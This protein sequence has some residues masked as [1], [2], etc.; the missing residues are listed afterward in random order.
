MVN[1]ER[2]RIFGR[3][4]VGYVSTTPGKSLFDQSSLP[5]LRVNLQSQFQTLQI[6]QPKSMYSHIYA[7][8]HG[9]THLAL[10]FT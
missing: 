2:R 5:Y 7:F 10:Q 4:R 9:K 8:L 1:H 6:R 3:G